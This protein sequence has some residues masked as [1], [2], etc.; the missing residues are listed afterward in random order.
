M[1]SLMRSVV[2]WNSNARASLSPSDLCEICGK[3]P[4][5]IE[6]GFKHPYCGRTCA[7][8]GQMLFPGTGECLLLG[9][10]A[11]GRTA[12]ANFC[13]DAHGRDAVCLGQVAG[14]ERCEVQPRSVG[15]LCAACDRRARAALPKLRQLK[16]DGSTTFKNLRA[17]F[18]SE[19]EVFPTLPTV[20]KVYEIHYGSDIRENYENYENDHPDKVLIR[21]FHA[22]QCICD[23]GTKSASLC[24]FK[25][26]GICPI[27]K[28]SF[29]EFAFGEQYNVGR[30]GKGIYV[31]R[32][33][34]LADRHATSCSSSP[35]RVMIAC[36]TL[37]DQDQLDEADDR[38]SIFIDCVD[39][40]HP[41]YI[42]MY[43]K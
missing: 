13:S 7:R 30:F 8:K 32:D 19:W 23:M 35:Y 3:K 43:C 33:P 39:A 16:P 28:S 1:S 17:Q 22:A 36:D 27:V 11:A 21:T 41:A 25:S 31:Y 26:C 6:K 14:C 34:S 4:K 29:G 24:D 38:E 10:R 15:S 12:K 2:N 42:I 40:I 5:Y 20:E 9:C 18:R 37:V